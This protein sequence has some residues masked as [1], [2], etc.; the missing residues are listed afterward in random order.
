MKTNYSIEFAF[1]KHHFDG[2]KSGGLFEIALNRSIVI[3]IIPNYEN[4]KFPYPPTR[5]RL[6]MLHE[7]ER[8]FHSKNEQ[9]YYQFYTADFVLY[10]N[11]KKTGHIE[12]LDFTNSKPNFISKPVVY[13][14]DELSYSKMRYEIRDKFP[15]YVSNKRRGG[16]IWKDYT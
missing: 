9:R 11:P 3:R 15:F 14:I 8:D 13:F 6:E 7:M 1:G 12:H 16:K 10:V 5:E 4:D 2:G